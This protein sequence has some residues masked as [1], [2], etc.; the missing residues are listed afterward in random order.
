MTDV[1]PFL[2]TLDWGTTRLRAMLVSKNGRVVDHSSADEG[3]MSVEPGTFPATLERHV[4]RWLDRHGA[5]PII[6]AG[7]VGSRNGWVE[8]P[9]IA[10]PTSRAAIGERLTRV[11]FARTE[12]WLVPGLS[13]R[14]QAGMADVMRGEETKIIGA[15]LDDGTVV[16]PGTH[17][18]WAF[19]RAGG[20]EGFATFMTGDFYG[21]LMGHTILGTLAEEP[22]DEIGFA[23]GLAVAEKGGGLTHQAFAART[24]VLL[25]DIGPREVGPFLSGLLI[26]SEIAHGLTLERPPGEIVLVADGVFARHY[27][28]G[29]SYFGQDVRVLDPEECVVTGLVTLFQSLRSGARHG[30]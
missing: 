12:V 17:A 11:P 14:D 29:F 1:S 22:C 15:G 3:I 2:I 24:G 30:I 23:R 5:L 9:Y 10:C 4:G 16:M 25:G 13:A 7:M 18:K 20:V 27:A 8:A 19:M 6:M 26:G 21:A 28:Q